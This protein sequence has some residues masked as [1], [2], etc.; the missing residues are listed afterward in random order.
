MH[1]GQTCASAEL[2]ATAKTDALLAGQEWALTARGNPSMDGIA[3]RA[4]SVSPAYTT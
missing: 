2:Y 3:C 4:T 1:T